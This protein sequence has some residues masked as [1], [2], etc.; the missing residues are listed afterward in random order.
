MSLSFSI[1][2][3]CKTIKL[4]LKVLIL[5]KDVHQYIILYSHSQHSQRRHPLLKMVFVLPAMKVAE[6]ET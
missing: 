6:G 5:M 1:L 4:K 2:L 3:R